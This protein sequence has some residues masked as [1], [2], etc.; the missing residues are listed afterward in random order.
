MKDLLK[1]ALS[2]VE[3][4]PSITKMVEMRV[5]SERLDNALK[6]F[7]PKAEVAPLLKNPD[8]VKLKRFLDQQR[9]TARVVKEGW[10]RAKLKGEVPTGAGKNEKIAAT[11][12][13]QSKA[14]DLLNELSKSPQDILRE[15]FFALARLRDEAAIYDAFKKM[16]GGAKVYDLSK[17]VGFK[18]VQKTTQSGNTTV[19]K[20]ATFENALEKLEPY[21]ESLADVPR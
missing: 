2:A 16:T 8:Y 5:V 15:K 12:L 13:E 11:A 3:Q 17:A 1:R 9:P 7:V 21:L 18:V 20:K 14:R 10:S 6:A 19:D 4:D